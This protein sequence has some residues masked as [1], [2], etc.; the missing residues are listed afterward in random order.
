M[1]LWYLENNFELLYELLALNEEEAVDEADMGG[2]A[3]DRFN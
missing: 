1:A 3:C 2:E